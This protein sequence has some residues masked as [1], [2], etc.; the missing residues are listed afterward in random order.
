MKLVESSLVEHIDCKNVSAQEAQEILG[1]NIIPEMVQIVKDHSGLGL[2]APQ[3]GIYKRFFV[4]VHKDAYSVFFNPVL[5]KVNNARYIEGEGCLNY[6][7]GKKFADVKRFKSID[8]LYDVWTEDNKFI[9]RKDRFHGLQ[10]RVIQHEV[11]HLKGKT[12]FI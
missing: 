3:V 5:I 2:A 11:D 9:R 12:I 10:A 7:G 8:I 6:E 4:L 1:S